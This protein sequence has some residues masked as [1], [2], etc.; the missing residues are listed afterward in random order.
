MLL[1]KLLLGLLQ[2]AA[3]TMFAL[4]YLR[5]DVKSSSANDPPIAPQNESLVREIEKELDKAGDGGE[6]D[7]NGKFDRFV[8][9]L[10]DA[11][12]WDFLFSE[13][14]EMNYLKG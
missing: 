12:R 4:K 11:W 6:V 7:G 14:T 13:G 1:I 3:L 5:F 8:Y 2:V 10:L 9:F